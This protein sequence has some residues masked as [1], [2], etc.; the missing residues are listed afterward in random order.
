MTV[1]AAPPAPTEPDAGVIEQA[2]RR[3]RRHRFGAL[4][5]TAAAVLIPIVWSAGGGSD[6]A[7][8]PAQP[9]FAAPAALAACAFAPTTNATLDPSLLSVLGILRRA[10]AP[11]DA[12]P[13]GPLRSAALPPVSQVFTKYVRRARELA[14]RSYYVIAV[15]FHPCG[16]HPAADT[17]SLWV[18]SDKEAY[19]VGGGSAAIIAARGIYDSRGTG[20]GAQASVVGLVPDGVAAATLHYPAAPSHGPGH[21]AYPAITLSA[22]AI[23]NV[24]IFPRAPRGPGLGSNATMTWRAADGAVIKTLS[25]G[26][27]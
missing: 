4:A 15:R 3:Q 5:A 6:H 9:A 11:A 21:S 19:G 7:Q 27:L 20:A 1:T 25:G 12:L 17:A 2:R 10:A 24:V 22:R 23:N 14:G 16:T 13:E 26:D 18:F 8:P